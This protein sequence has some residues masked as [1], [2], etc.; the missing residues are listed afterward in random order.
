[1][2]KIKAQTIKKSSDIFYHLLSIIQMQKMTTQVSTSIIIY[3][4]FFNIFK[5]HFVDAIYTRFEIIAHHLL[6]F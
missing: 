4:N 6:S 5:F 1:M 2:R 3:F